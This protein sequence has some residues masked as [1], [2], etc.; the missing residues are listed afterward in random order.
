MESLLENRQVRKCVIK[1]LRA[2]DIGSRTAGGDYFAQEEG[3]WVTDS[4][5]ASPMSLYPEYQTTL[6]SWGADAIGSVFVEVETEDG[7]IGLATGFGGE[8]ACYL[9]EKHFR[10]FVVGS[11]PRDIARIW[12]QMYRAS[13]PYGRK[14]LAVS[15]IG[16][17]DLALWDLLGKLRSEPVYKL[18]GGAVRDDLIAYCTGPCPARYKE[19]G[20]FGAKVPLPFGPGE[21]PAGLK[22]NVEFL[23]QHRQAVG[24]NFP[25]MVDCFMS[26]DV[27]YARDLARAVKD[28]DVYWFEEALHADDWEGYRQLKS[29]APWVRWATGEHEYSRYGFRELIKDRAIDVLQPDVMHVGGLT[30][31][32]RIAAMAAAYDIPVVPHCGGS[33]SYHF[34]ITQAHSPFVEY[35]NASTVGDQIVP[36]LGPMFLGE[37]LPEGGRITLSND[38]GWGL[39][40]DRDTV[41]LRRVYNMDSE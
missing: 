7:L 11:D 2:F 15:A 20:F 8:P 34:S 19:L 1:A 18:I 39:T 29:A 41:L 5:I 28:L 31:V 9:I 37:P 6:K 25:L 32:L 17:V 35:F 23:A 3:H 16:A 21:G 38:P 33:Y 30:E 40:L 14:G 24:P 27:G 4:R 36:S 10:R 26:L 22:S 13:S 12:D